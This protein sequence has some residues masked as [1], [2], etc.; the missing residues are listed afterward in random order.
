MYITHLEVFAQT[1]IVRT[2]VEQHCTSA[3]RISELVGTSYANSTRDLRISNLRN[4]S[5][6]CFKRY[7]AR[8]LKVPGANQGSH[9]SWV[10]RD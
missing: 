9:S 7:T 3:M 1:D 10:S 4:N 2:S 5:K 6:L 8:N